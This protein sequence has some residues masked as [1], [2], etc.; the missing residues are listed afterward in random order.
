MDIAIVQLW[1]PTWL[2]I[3]KHA[4]VLRWETD[5]CLFEAHLPDHLGQRPPWGFARRDYRSM[6]RYVYRARHLPMYS[7][8][9]TSYSSSTLLGIEEIVMQCRQRTIWQC[10]GL[11]LTEMLCGY[12]AC[13]LYC[14]GILR[15]TSVVTVIEE[16]CSCSCSYLQLFCLFRVFDTYSRPD[17]ILYLFSLFFHLSDAFY[18][19]DL[20]AD[21]LVTSALVSTV[22]L[23]VVFVG[24]VSIVLAEHCAQYRPK[25]LV[26]ASGCQESATKD[27]TPS[28]KRIN[29]S[30][31]RSR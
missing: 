1:S 14:Y 27:G 19:R 4:L 7:R 17:V 11:F 26:A 18:V 12:T 30:S 25:D 20:V 22:L 3:V 8:Y 29:R 9:S 24:Y 15:P 5:R 2:L 21:L 10:V 28:T 6:G 13:C 16:R 31:P 23:A